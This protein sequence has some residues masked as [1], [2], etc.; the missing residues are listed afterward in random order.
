[1]SQE[2]F[3][4]AEIS[5]DYK[6]PL[7]N[8]LDDGT[9]CLLGTVSA[10]SHPEISPK[11][12]IIVYDSDHLAFWERSHRGAAGNIANN[13]QVVVF[14]RNPDHAE[15][16]PQGAAL[17]LY[18]TASVI[19]DAAVTTDVYDRMCEREQKAD[20]GRKGHAVMIAVDR[21]TNLRGDDV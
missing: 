2:E 7:E 18:G 3:T 1:M 11:G 5:S 6:A 14:Y 20:S 13:A 9:P 16:L 19:E 17:R 8:A 12:S 10:D 15:S 4:M 21:I